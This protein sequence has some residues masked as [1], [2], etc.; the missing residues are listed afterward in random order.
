[1]TTK[2]NNKPNKDGPSLE[3]WV[4]LYTHYLYNWALFKTSDK[5]VAEDLLQDTFLAAYQQLTAFNGDSNPKTWLLAILNNKIKG[6]YRARCKDVGYNAHSKIEDGQMFAKFFDDNDRWK[7]EEKPS[8]WK[9]DQ[10]HLLDD[11]EFNKTLDS[12]ME[13]LPEQWRFAMNLKYIEEKKGAL[14]C[15]ELDISP[16]NF[17]QIL[18]RAKLQL[19]KCLEMKWFKA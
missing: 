1:M 8:F 14:I 12:C 10:T 9:V 11:P 4:K 13:S 16:T 6:Y 17:W 15:Q 7:K 2:N 3:R 19:R 18:H 5:Q